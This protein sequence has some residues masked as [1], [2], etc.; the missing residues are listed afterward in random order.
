M[1]LFVAQRGAFLGRLVAEA[2]GRGGWWGKLVGRL[3]GEAAGEAVG[4]QSVLEK[5]ARI[6]TLAFS[7]MTLSSVRVTVVSIRN[8]KGRA[9]ASDRT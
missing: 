5:T 8:T 2:G 1:P 6:V 9:G 7:G 3:L 4:K